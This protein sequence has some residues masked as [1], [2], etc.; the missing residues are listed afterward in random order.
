MLYDR[1]AEKLDPFKQGDEVAQLIVSLICKAEKQY[2]G[3]PL[4]AVRLE[5]VTA[6]VVESVVL[7]ADPSSSIIARH[8]VQV[9]YCNIAKDLPDYL[10]SSKTAPPAPPRT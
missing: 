7:P 1:P 5:R 6:A 3:L 10:R 9:L 8:M 4:G 2:R